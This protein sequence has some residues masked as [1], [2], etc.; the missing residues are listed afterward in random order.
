M[1][2]KAYPTPGHTAGSVT[3]LVN[4]TLYLVTPRAGRATAPARRRGFSDDVAQNRQAIEA[5]ASRLRAEHAEVKKLAFA[6]SGPLD[7]VDALNA[8][9]AAN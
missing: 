7:G 3:Y 9:R 6:H 4:G 5:L 2:V 8:F 1:S